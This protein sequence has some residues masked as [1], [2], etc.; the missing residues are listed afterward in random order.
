M[1]III[2][3]ANFQLFLPNFASCLTH[4]SHLCTT[5]TTYTRFVLCP[6]CLIIMSIIEFHFFFRVAAVGLFSITMF[7]LINFFAN[8]VAIFRKV[9][10][11]YMFFLPINN[12][13]HFLLDF[14]ILAYIPSQTQ[15]S[16]TLLK[17]RLC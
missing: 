17:V 15:K 2:I 4:I 14:A 8:L 16:S 13:A 6:I 12:Y 11:V 7:G 5:L 1:F 10:S 9:L 3:Q